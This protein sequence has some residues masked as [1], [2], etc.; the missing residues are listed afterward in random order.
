M[1]LDGCL[2][3]ALCIPTRGRRTGEER[4]GHTELQGSLVIMCP[5]ETWEFKHQGRRREWHWG[6]SV[7]SAIAT[8]PCP[9]H[10]DHPCPLSAHQPHSGANTQA[11]HQWINSWTHCCRAAAGHFRACMPETSDS[12]SLPELL[13][14]DGAL[15]RSC[16]CPPLGVWSLSL[17]CRQ[18][19]QTQARALIRWKRSHRIPSGP[20]PTEDIHPKPSARPRSFQDHFLPGPLLPSPHL[21]INAQTTFE[22]DMLISFPRVMRMS[23]IFFSPQWQTR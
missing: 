13:F 6:P 7:A 14:H 19:L 12:V 17:P 20:L 21:P 9:W 2:S 15:S 4:H 10:L 3:S 11:E 18:C 8:F 16:P 22:L 23:K 5:A 1:V